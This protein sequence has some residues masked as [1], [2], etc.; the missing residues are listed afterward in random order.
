MT[1][2]RTRSPRTIVLQRSVP[3][4]VTPLPFTPLEAVQ[5]FDLGALARAKSARI[6]VG[7]YE[8]GCCRRVVYAVIRKGMVTKFELEPCK[9]PVKLTPEWKGVLRDVHKALRAG[10]GKVEKFPIPVQQLPSAVMRLKYTIW[11][12]VKI[13]WFG[14]C[15]TCCFDAN[16]RTSTW[17]KCS[18]VKAPNP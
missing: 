3:I 18:I 17:S 12:C 7:H 9:D 15:L 14:Y 5:S 1:R 10:G 11:V 6:E 4:E 16:S 8:T 2:S 13:C